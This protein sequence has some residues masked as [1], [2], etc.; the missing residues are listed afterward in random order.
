MAGKFAYSPLVLAA[1]T[2]GE[3]MVLRQIAFWYP[4]AKTERAGHTWLI[5][6]AKEF[7]EHGVDLEEDTIWR[8]VRA[9]HKRGV[10][11]KE[12]HYHP[13]KPCIGPVFWIRPLIEIDPPLIKSLGAI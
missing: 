8:I 6:S 9:L 7:R 12:R 1:K 4:K 3:S 5:Q 2:K 10:I 11:V 13:Y